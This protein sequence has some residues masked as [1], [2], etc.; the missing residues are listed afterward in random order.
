[1]HNPAIS[2]I[3]SQIQLA[4]APVFLLAGVGAL[5]NVVASRLARVVDRARKVAAA[6]E[7]LDP[8]E[9]AQAKEELRLLAKRIKAAN[10]A[11]VCC[12]ASA[13]FVCVVVAIMFIAEPTRIGADRVI[14]ILFI[15]AMALLILGLML[16]LYEIR[17]AMKSLRTLSNWKLHEG[18]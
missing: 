16:F 6:A 9:S 5:L 13:L 15:V 7:S 4:V 18:P 11:I 1:M 17:L 12:T 3:A 2:A 14:A 10:L 8:E